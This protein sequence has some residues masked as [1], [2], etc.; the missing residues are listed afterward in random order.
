MRSQSPNLAERDVLATYER[1]GDETLE[2]AIA[3]AFRR[4]GIDVMERDVP[5]H[6]MVDVDALRDLH[7]GPHPTPIRTTLVLYD[8][9]VT[10]TGEAVRVY[11]PTDAE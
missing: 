10:I 8:H 11:A 2:M 5:F 3:R 1:E 4:A 6:E 7:R 9:P